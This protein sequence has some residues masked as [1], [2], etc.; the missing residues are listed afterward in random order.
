MAVPGVVVFTLERNSPGLYRP[1]SSATP[2]GSVSEDRQFGEVVPAMDSDAS[3][4]VCGIEAER[5]GNRH[6]RSALQPAAG[7]PLPGVRRLCLA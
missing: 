5:V 2:C 7:P 6:R 4:V 3:G 1:Y